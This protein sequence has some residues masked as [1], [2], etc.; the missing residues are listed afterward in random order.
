MSSPYLGEK[1]GAR[2]PSGDISFIIDLGF[3]EDPIRDIA[4]RHLELAE[5]N[6]VKRVG[7]KYA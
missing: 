1:K 2:R 4:L 7:L 3:L 5:E 6:T